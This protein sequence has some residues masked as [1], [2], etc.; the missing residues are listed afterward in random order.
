MIYQSETADMLPCLCIAA[1]PNSV[2]L[3]Q[4]G[5]GILWGASAV[6]LLLGQQESFCLTDLS[7]QVLQ[8]A[9]LEAPH[10]GW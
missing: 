9:V 10:P 2:E 1:T 4:F 5:D 7:T 3:A 8:N 6:L